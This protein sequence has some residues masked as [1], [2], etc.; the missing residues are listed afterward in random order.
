VSENSLHDIAAAIL[1][2][3]SAFRFPARGRS[4]SPFIKDGDIA[5]VE[6]ASNAGTTIRLGDV[7]LCSTTGGRLAMHRVTKIRRR[8]GAVNYTTQGNANA[9]PDGEKRAQDILGRVTEIERGEKRRELGTVQERLIGLLWIW[10]TPW[11]QRGYHLC[12]R[13]KSHLRYR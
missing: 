6:P 11:S 13:I 8:D 9:R 4:M 2:Q 1:K 5:L 7:V 10:A 3:G 12:R